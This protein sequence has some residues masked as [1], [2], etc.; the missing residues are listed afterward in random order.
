MSSYKGE[1]ELTI[2]P[3]IIFLFNISSNTP[4]TS[5]PIQCPNENVEETLDWLRDTFRTDMGGSAIGIRLVDKFEATIKY[6]NA[7]GNNKLETVTEFVN[8]SDNIIFADEVMTHEE[9]GALPNLEDILKD[10]QFLRSQFRSGYSDDGYVYYKVGDDYEVGGR[11]V[12]GIYED[13][14]FIDKSGT[15]LWP[16]DEAVGQKLTR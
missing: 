12:D 11:G 9:F 3:H 13:T 15:R 4:S 2:T 16:R 6:E 8:K 1:A 5:K 10:N 7:K 14:I